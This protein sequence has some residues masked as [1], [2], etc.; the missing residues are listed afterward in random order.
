MQSKMFTAAATAALM[1][2]VLS[3]AAPAQAQQ[4][5]VEARSG[6]LSVEPFVGVYFDEYVGVDFISS[7]YGRRETKPGILTGVSLGY[8]LDERLRLTGNLGYAKVEEFGP[9]GSDAQNHFIYGSKSLF[10]TGGAE[11]DLLPGRTRLSLGVE[12]GVVASAETDE[13]VVGAPSEGFREAYQDHFNNFENGYD[14][15]DPV[16]VPNLTLGYRLAPGVALDLGVRDY[17][18]MNDSSLNQNPAVTFG[19]SLGG[20]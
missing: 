5:P 1:T 15:I 2:G 11:Y 9:F 7:P 8:S 18:F 3:P 14:Q 17:V 12:A 6:G 16:V 4:A 10:A 19:I 20:R 13:G